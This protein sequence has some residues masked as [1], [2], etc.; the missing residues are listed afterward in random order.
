MGWES[1]GVVGF[2]LG[3]LLQGQKSEVL[4]IVKYLQHM[5]RINVFGHAILNIQSTIFTPQ[6]L[7]KKLVRNPEVSDVVNFSGTLFGGGMCATS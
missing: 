1:F 3:P 6:P 4:S 5:T 7:R 2:D